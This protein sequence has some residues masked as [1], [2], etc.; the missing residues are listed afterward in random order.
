MS[1]NKRKCL[2]A[3]PASERCQLCGHCHQW[4]TTPVYKRH[5]S[6]FYN[7]QLNTWQRAEEL[8]SSE[9][10]TDQNLEPLKFCPP[11]NESDE[12]QGMLHI[13]MYIYFFP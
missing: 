1:D 12:L 9:S 5:R 13:Y 4:L 8:I 2:F 6:N 10:D 11:S 7:T 3:R